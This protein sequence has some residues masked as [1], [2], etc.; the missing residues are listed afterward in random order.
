[1]PSKLS[2]VKELIKEL[3]GLEESIVELEDSFVNLELDDETI[4]DTY[5]EEVAEICDKPLDELGVEIQKIERI[6]DELIG[7]LQLLPD[8]PVKEKLR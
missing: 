2:D 5:G 3:E 4:K 8:L 7:A 6:I 1:M